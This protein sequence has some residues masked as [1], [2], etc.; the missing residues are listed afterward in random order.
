MQNIHSSF[1]DM[2]YKVV[3]VKNRSTVGKSSTVIPNTKATTGSQVTEA[4]TGTQVTKS[5]TGTQVTE[6][7][8]GTQVN[9]ATTVTTITKA[10]T[11]IS[12]T[13]NVQIL[14]PTKS[15]AST[16]HL[17]RNTKF[18]RFSPY[19][20]LLVGS[21]IGNTLEKKLTCDSVK[22]INDSLQQKGSDVSG[23]KK[24]GKYNYSL[25]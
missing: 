21:K 20:S 14:F 22:S 24:A 1:S 8:T 10:N 25:I 23:D 19:R 2:N 17:K 16:H 3:L 6:A 13:P 15:I 4:T 18:K 9:E 12:N 5:T 7:T 11:G